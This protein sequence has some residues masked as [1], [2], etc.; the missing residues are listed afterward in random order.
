M[1]L[2]A[3]DLAGQL[4]ADVVGIAAC[5][6]LRVI[7]SDGYVPDDLIQKD[8]E[9]LEK[10]ISDAE[11]E[12]RAVMGK[13]GSNLEWRSTVTFGPLSDYL[14]DQ[15]RCAD[16]MVTGVHQSESIFDTSRHVDIG[17]LVIQLGR[18]VLIV[19]TDVEKIILECIL[20]AWKETRE[21]RR[22]VLDALPLLRKAN[23]VVVCEIASKE[24]M[25]AA[26][27]HLTDVVG[28]LK[29]DGIT[30]EPMAALSTGDDA[31]GLDVVAS[32][33]A[34]DIIVAGAYG[35]SRL[36]EWALGGVT[37]DLLLRADRCAFVSH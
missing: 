13:R 15:A 6:P 12:F 1:L 30:A 32:D 33:R 16:I 23:H 11:T 25:T 34:A 18:P 17:D 20:V 8:R 27:Q 5:Q 4:S 22:A 7:Y 19:P 21:S 9:A 24:E 36:R 3:S 2:A 10:D 35:H 29:R 31:A 28:W 14:A 26:R 37:K